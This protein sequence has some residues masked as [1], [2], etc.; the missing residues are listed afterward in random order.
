[1]PSVIICPKNADAINYDGVSNEIRKNVPNIT[2]DGIKKLIGYAI[3]DAGFL[4]MDKLLKNMTNSEH[5]DRIMQLELWRG[6][7]SLKRFFEDLFEKWGYK[8]EQVC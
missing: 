8:C 2:E 7:R 1:M 3:A 5:K 6:R 4:N